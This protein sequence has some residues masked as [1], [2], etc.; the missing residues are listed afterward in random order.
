[1]SFCI[2]IHVFDSL[3]FSEWSIRKKKKKRQNKTLQYIILAPSQ[4]RLLILLKSLMNSE[5]SYLD[6]QTIFFFCIESLGAIFCALN[7]LLI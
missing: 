1:M 4:T 2:F 5:F 7:C 6:T 3:T